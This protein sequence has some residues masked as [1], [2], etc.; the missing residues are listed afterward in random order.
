MVLAKPKVARTAAARAKSGDVGAQVEVFF[1]WASDVLSGRQRI[2][3]L[4][5]L[6]VLGVMVGTVAVGAGAYLLLKSKVVA[7]S[8]SD[9]AALKQV[10]YTGEPW[11]VECTTDRSASPMVYKAESSL[12]SVQIGTLDC[13]A[14]LP[15]GKTTYERFK[16]SRPS[17]GPVLLAAANTERPQIVPKNVLSNEVCAT[18]AHARDRAHAI[19]QT[20]RG[21]GS[22]TPCARVLARPPSPPGSSVRPSRSSTHRIAARSSRASACASRGAWLCSRACMGFERAPRAPLKTSAQ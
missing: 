8:P 22:V 15:S 5:L 18:R 14:L 21:G 7:L 6:T 4:Q 9:T 3:F 1:S 13:G 2:T 12:K 20:M 10:F 19:P 11:L 17:Y 16:L